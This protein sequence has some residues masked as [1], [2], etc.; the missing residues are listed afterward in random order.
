MTRLSFADLGLH[1]PWELIAIEGLLL[2]RFD[3]IPFRH[4]MSCRCSICP[5]LWECWFIVIFE[6]FCAIELLMSAYGISCLELLL[7]VLGLGNFDSILSVRSLLCFGFP[8]SA[9]GLSCTGL[10]LSL[11]DMVSLDSSPSLRTSVCLEFVMLIW[12]LHM[13]WVISTPAGLCRHWT[14]FVMSQLPP[15]GLCFERLWNHTP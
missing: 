5:G 10:P 4:G 3:L 7:S 15:L 13:A 1:L 9:Y 12:G 8:L 14:F 6:I 11:P 2:T